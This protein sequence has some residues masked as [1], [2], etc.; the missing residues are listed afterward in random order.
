M[1]SVLFPPLT[2]LKPVPQYLRIVRIRQ[3][4]FPQYKHPPTLLSEAIIIFSIARCVSPKLRLPELRVRLRQARP[5]AADMLVPKATVDEENGPPFWERQVR[6]ARQVAAKEAES[7]AQ[8][9]CRPSHCQFR[10]RMLA[11][12]GAHVARPNLV[13]WRRTEP[14]CPANDQSSF[15]RNGSN[16][17]KPS[18]PMLWPSF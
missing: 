12:D 11:A 3:F 15:C 6:P 4:A 9:V 16:S 2:G 17:S 14:H 1:A 18:L 8:R 5:R 7:Q 13:R 10:L